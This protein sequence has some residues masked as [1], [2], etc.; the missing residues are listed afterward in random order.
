MRSMKKLLKKA[1]VFTLTAA[2][3]VG[4]PLTAS[5]A[6][7]NSV[8]SVSDGTDANGNESGTGTVTNTDTN[9]TSTVLKDN[10]ARI[11]GI[12]LDQ[13]E[14]TAEVDAPAKDRQKIK[15]T[16]IME[17]GDAELTAEE[18][19]E[20]TDSLESK[21]K[22]EV[23]NLDETKSNPVPGTILAIE[24]SAADRTVVTLN[25]KKG[26]KEKLIV[27][28]TID[29][30][31]AF[32]AERNE[33]GTL[34]EENGELVFTKVELGETKDLLLTAD[35]KVFVKEYSKDLWFDWNQNGVKDDTDNAPTAYLKHTMD[36]NKYLA[37]DR[38][39]ANDTITWIS[40]NTKAATVTAA[41]VVTFKGTKTNVNGKIIAV[42][43]RGKKVEWAFEVDPGVAAS[44]VEIVKATDSSLFTKNK[45]EVDLNKNTTKADG[46]SVTDAT[47]ENSALGVK[48]QMYAKVNAATDA[49]KNLILADSQTALEALGDSIVDKGNETKHKYQAAKKDI[50]DGKWYYE[51]DSKGEN[52]VAK[53]IKVT[54]VINWTSNKAAFANV[55]SD[56]GFANTITATNVGKASVTAKASNGKKAS[57]A[58]TVKATL[59]ALE[60]DPV[61]DN[62][63]YSG[64]N[65][66]LTYTPDPKAS[67]D[68]VKWS[69]KA[70]KGSD[71]VKNQA[72]ISGKGVLT[73]KPQVACDKI[74]VTLE[75]KKNGIAAGGEE[76]KITTTKDFAIKQSSI[77]GITVQDD[78]NVVVANVYA[79]YK[80]A[81][82]TKCSIKK[83]QLQSKKDNTTTIQAEK[84]RT[85]AVT[86]RPAVY[87]ENSDVSTLSW[88]TSKAAVAD[89]T[90]N[91]NTVLITAKQKGSATITVS[92][93]RVDE[94]NKAKAINTTFEVNVEQPV[95]TL[96]MN[97]PAV[98]LNQKAGKI[99]K[100]AVDAVDQKV[101]LKVTLGPKGVN[102][103]AAVHWTVTDV[104][105]NKTLEA[106]AVG[107]TDKKGAAITKA[108]VSVTLPT[109]KVGDVF[110]ITARTD[111]GA[112]ATSTVTVVNK[113]SE[114]AIA[115][116]VTKDDKGNVTEHVLFSTNVKGKD[117]P[118]THEVK[119]GDAE[120]LM[121][122]I[123]NI[124]DAE[125][126]KDGT[127]KWV[128]EGTN[129]AEKVTYTVNKKG[130][131]NIDADGNVYAVNTGKVTITAKTPLGKKATLTVTVTK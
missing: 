93:V 56:E 30:R 91:G 31:Y 58:V 105:N 102:N 14:I 70:F 41:G 76:K 51:V 111:S 130:I 63:L 48:V 65:V 64:Q 73:I 1:M 107:L 92:G 89:I 38:Q 110:R 88:K 75:S 67:K 80:D 5:A 62:T 84:G 118:N 77:D 6:P 24:A 23:L 45:T 29:G 52:Y 108:N 69:V 96:T 98:V 83:N 35:A 50:A 68:G 86:V 66:T 7:L 97:K 127:P 26:N 104:K 116:T 47:H 79:D 131:V 53:Q 22:W 42:S 112:S 20:I 32:V 101:A 40:D 15:A 17:W 123:I 16:I 109:P 117:K 4:T 49:S 95:K 82:K 126:K 115:K 57:L 71:E 33:D 28:A 60:I 78:K 85:Y 43:E 21:I 81:T 36:L 74:T 44:K 18:K 113:A 54:D 34:K 9:T 100:V 12:S 2:M 99:N 129:N 114:I 27:R 37:R 119:I 25:P 39:T 55:A 121:Q 125:K 120:F 10:A 59:G 46:W 19:E 103:K 124:G 122:P 90:N 72:S 11:I 106:S 61:K 3:L 128:V 8:F 87:G 13:T 94:K